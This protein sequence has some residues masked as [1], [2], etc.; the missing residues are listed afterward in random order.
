M[1]TLQ[2]DKIKKSQGRGRERKKERKNVAEGR[3]KVYMGGNCGWFTEYIAS[4]LHRRCNKYPRQEEA[5]FVVVVVRRP[6]N[7]GAFFDGFSISLV[8]TNSAST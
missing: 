8:A 4:T 7:L 2:C 3:I 6:N 1:D 5:K